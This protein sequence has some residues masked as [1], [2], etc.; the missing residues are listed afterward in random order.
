MS[1]IRHNKAT[2]RSVASHMYGDGPWR[3]REDKEDGA[4]R[5]FEERETR[6]R[7]GGGS[8]I[9]LSTAN[10]VRF[11]TFPIAFGDGNVTQ[12]KTKKKRKEPANGVPE[13]NVCKGGGTPELS[14]LAFFSASFFYS[15]I[16]HHSFYP[17]LLLLLVSL[18]REREKREKFIRRALRRAQVC[19]SRR[20]IWAAH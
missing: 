20:R 1:R 17:I 5:F 12:K 14:I 19:S 10:E 3:K 16:L 9:V 11:D 13:R 18:S 2:R 15:I 4:T 7:G 8:C 6:G